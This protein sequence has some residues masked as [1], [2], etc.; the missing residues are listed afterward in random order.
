[1]QITFICHADGVAEAAAM[2]E[3]LNGGV[4]VTERLHM[5]ML[6]SWRKNK[7]GVRRQRKKYFSPI[8]PNALIEY[9]LCKLG[10]KQV[11]QTI[12][13]LSNLTERPAAL[14]SHV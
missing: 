12:L 2:T 4:L 10:S 13:Q 8:R 7:K 9:A 6:P 3:G 1:M 14:S 5:S 11:L